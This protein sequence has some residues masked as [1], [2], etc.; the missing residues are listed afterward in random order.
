MFT[1]EGAGTSL[2]MWADTENTG[3][4]LRHFMKGLKS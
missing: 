2:I 3:H 1:D 4:K